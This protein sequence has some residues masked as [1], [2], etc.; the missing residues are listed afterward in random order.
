MAFKAWVKKNIKTNKNKQIFLQVI[1]KHFHKSNCFLTIMKILI[2]SWHT[3]LSIN[4]GWE[5]VC[6]YNGIY[7]KS[8]ILDKLFYYYNFPNTGFYYYWFFFLASFFILPRKMASQAYFNTA[9][10]IPGVKGDFMAKA[11]FCW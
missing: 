9:K 6:N 8:W 11:L 4:H 2:F 1:I 3:Y 5:I 10:A 7:E